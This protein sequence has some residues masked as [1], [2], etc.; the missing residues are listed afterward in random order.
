[1]NKIHTHTK[2]NCKLEMSKLQ[3]GGINSSVNVEEK[4][5]RE[6]YT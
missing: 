6:R 3:K 4:Y 1:M 2:Q 5:F